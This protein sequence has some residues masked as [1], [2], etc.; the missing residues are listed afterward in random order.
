MLGR[1]GDDIMENNIASGGFQRPQLG[2]Q[3]LIPC[4]HAG[5]AD[6]PPRGRVMCGGVS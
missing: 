1:A 2:I 3:N 6:Q 5:I 4:G